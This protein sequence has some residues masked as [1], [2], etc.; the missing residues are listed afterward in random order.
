VTQA[1]YEAIAVWS[2]I[3]ASVLFIIAMIW[4]FAKW[5]RPAVIAAEAKK[6]AD[7]LTA[8]HQ[9]NE[10]RDE[11]SNAQRRLAEANAEVESIQARARA[12]GQRERDRILADARVEGERVVHN[13]NGELARGRVASR[14]SYRDEL[15][16]DALRI[17][18]ERA[19][20]EI[21]ETAN[22]GIVKRVLDAVDANVSAA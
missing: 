10:A 1:Q 15:L 19:G 13:A 21:D 11:V 22:F 17:A 5:V 2:E 16:R 14:E 18:T 12:D 8:E 7:L 3:L 6:N 4:I 20:R 9:R